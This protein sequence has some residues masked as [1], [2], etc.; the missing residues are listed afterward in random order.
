MSF[1]IKT[2]PELWLVSKTPQIFVEW[3]SIVTSCD[4][5]AEIEKNSKTSKKQPKNGHFYH[6]FQFI[7]ISAAWSQYLTLVHN[8]IQFLRNFETIH[9]SRSI[10][11]VKWENISVKVPGWLDPRT[12]LICKKW[13]FISNQKFR[14]CCRT[15]IRG[16][17]GK[18]DFS[19]SNQW[20]YVYH[21]IL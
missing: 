10:L 15:K 2:D 8:C 20:I 3:I 13:Q 1:L 6:I 19:A 4:Q 18:W 21:K 16:I 7:F 12:L 11:I 9:K 14:S 5:A 17:M